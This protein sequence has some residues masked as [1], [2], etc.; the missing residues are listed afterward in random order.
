[1]HFISSLRQNNSPCVKVELLPKQNI[2][3][4][5]VSTKKHSLLLCSVLD[6]DKSNHM[7]VMFTEVALVTAVFSP[8]KR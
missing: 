6:T 2:M 1:M 8:D 7:T 5:S 4:M 3:C